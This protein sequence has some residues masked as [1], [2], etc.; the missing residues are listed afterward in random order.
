V[1]VVELTET[2]RDQEYVVRDMVF[3]HRV[4]AYWKEIDSFPEADLMSVSSLSRATRR[5]DDR[6]L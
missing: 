1:V 5:I 6:Q 4:V 2:R 3:S